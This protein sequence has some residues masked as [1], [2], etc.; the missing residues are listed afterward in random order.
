[1]ELSLHV[2]LIHA[3][4]TSSVGR[5]LF[6]LLA[7]PQELTMQITHQAN[8]PGVIIGFRATRGSPTVIALLLSLALNLQ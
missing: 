3:G 6:V 8:F 7:A 2:S 4:L 1:M 5:I